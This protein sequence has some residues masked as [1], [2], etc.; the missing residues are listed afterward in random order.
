MPPLIK[1][2]PLTRYSGNFQVTLVSL[3]PPVYLA[4]KSIILIL[5]VILVT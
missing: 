4:L 2:S 3:T 1:T 5:F